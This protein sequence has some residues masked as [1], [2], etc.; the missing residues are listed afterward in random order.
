MS[1]GW[2][3]Q[4]QRLTG[5]EKRARNFAKRLAWKRAHAAFER[6]L[7]DDPPTE[8]W[9]IS[10]SKRALAEMARRGRAEG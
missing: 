2:D 5:A 6:L 10:E 4:E 8:R 3:D 7:Q 9:Q 1:T